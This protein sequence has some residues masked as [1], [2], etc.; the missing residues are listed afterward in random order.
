VLGATGAYTSL[1]A[2]GK[3][4]HPLHSLVSFSTQC[5]IVATIG[6]IVTKTPFIVPTQLDWLAM[7][8]M[9]GIFGFIAQVLL[10]MG[11]ARETAGRSSM[12]IYTQIVFATILERIFFHTVPAI[13]SVFGTLVIIS[14][15]LYVALTKD[16]SS[17]A[18]EDNKSTVR[19]RGGEEDSMECG[20]LR[21]DSEESEHLKDL[22]YENR[23][24]EGDGPKADDSS[25]RVTDL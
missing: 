19:L 18:G 7:L 10:T 4:A 16:S 1:R 2:I 15:A 25:R 14:C 20:I 23:D 11:L 9:I 3:R 17:G 21:R 6:M 12:A 5:V 24:K 22:E 8:I 13:L